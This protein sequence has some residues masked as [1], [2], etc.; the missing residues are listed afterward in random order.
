[1]GEDEDMTVGEKKNS[2]FSKMKI[3]KYLKASLCKLRKL[4]KNN[5][6]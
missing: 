1:V 3:Q 6:N 2:K 5:E 4:T